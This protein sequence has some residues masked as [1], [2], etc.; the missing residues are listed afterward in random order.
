[1]RD[2]PHHRHQASLESIFRVSSS[3]PL[4]AAQRNQAHRRFQ[5]ILD[6]YEGTVPPNRQ[7]KRPT[8]LRL[9]YHYASE[10]RSKDNVLRAFFDA[11]GLS[12]DENT[13][14]DLS[15][16]ETE[17]R[18]SIKL[19]GF[20]DFLID[21]FFLPPIEQ[22]RS[23]EP[24]FVG[25][26][27][28]LKTLRGDCLVR[29]RHRCVISRRFDQAVA[30]KRMQAKPNDARDDDHMLLVGEFDSLEVA[31]ILPHSL[32]KPNADLI[33]TNAQ[34]NHPLPDFL[35]CIAL[36]LTFSISPPRE[37]ISIEYWKILLDQ[38]CML[39]VRQRLGLWYS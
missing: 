34:S 16:K 1:M 13:S 36:S 25:T 4:E 23:S 10:G 14:V 30:V 39:M 24:T 19:I 38:V 31:H 27:A 6:H 22:S 9:T 28:R 20:A 3:P 8:L 29:D 2:F 15:D 33:F 12:I 5:E 35:Q 26:S 7:Y 21:N 11:I 18:I 17:E 37:L 32:I